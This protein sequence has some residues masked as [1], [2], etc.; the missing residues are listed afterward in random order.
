MKKIHFK[1]ISLVLISLLLLG[2]TMGIVSI[3]EI[4]SLGDENLHTLESRL[5][6]NFDLLI[7]SQV[8]SAVSILEQAY[9]R[10]DEIGLEAAIEEA[11]TYIRSIRYGESGYVFVN[12][13]NGVTIVLLGDEAEGTN[14]WDLQDANGEYII[15][16]LNEAALN[17]TGFT[18]YSYP[19]PGEDE[20]SPKRAYSQYFEPLDWILGTGVYVDDIDAIVAEEK[21]L[22]QKKILRMMVLISILDMSVIFFSIVLSW[23]LG[24]RISRPVEYLAGEARKL[25]MGDLTVVIRVDTSDETGDLAKAFSEMVSH[26][27]TSVKGIIQNAKDINHSVEEVAA[28]SQQVA[29]GASE[30]AASAEEISSS[31]EELSANIQQNTDN[32]RQSNTIVSKAAVDAATSGQAVED[33]V[34]SMKFISGKINIIEE[35][36]RNTNLLALNAA[37]EAARAGEVGKGFAVVASEVR[38]LAE[39]S[40]AAANDIT[41]ISADSVK[42]ADNTREMMRN[43]VPSIKK[44]AEIAEEIMEGSNEQARGAEQINTALLQMDKV[45]QSN[46]SSSEQIAAMSEELKKKSENLDRIVSFFKIDQSD[47]RRQGVVKSQAVELGA[48]ESRPK[49]KQISSPSPNNSSDIPEPSFSSEREDD[50]FAE[51]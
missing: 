49:G 23:F 26:L 20:A 33:V 11:K 46:A 17:N 37:I 21:A 4:R 30:Q 12:D 22:T 16:N 1:I 28:A 14:R 39:N 6:E 9:S 5:R 8:E 36:A 25:A 15:R 13:S 47:M 18:S 44:S 42:K 48:F 19:K 32:S 24:K 35:I 34:D 3:S 50:D 51:F 43:M 29:A 38:K 2:I 40:Q 7:Q 31:M 27:Q 41:Q 45:I 10:R